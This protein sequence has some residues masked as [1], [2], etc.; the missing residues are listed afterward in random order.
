[1]AQRLRGSRGRLQGA[2]CAPALAL[3][4]LDQRYVVPFAPMSRFALLLVALFLG[5]SC[6]APRPP[7]LGKEYA[8]V[9][10]GTIYPAA[11]A[12]PVE[13]LLMVDG[14]VL[15][16][17]TLAEMETR[18]SD[19]RKRAMGLKRKIDLRRIDL[20]GGTAVP[21][22]VDAHGHLESLGE[23]L[24][25][26][27]LLGCTSV[28]ELVQRVAERAAQRP[29]GT[30]ICGRGWDQTLFPGQAFPVHDTLSA[31]V[32]EHP[33]YLER[34][35]GHAAFVNAMALERV[36]FTGTLPAIEGG[37]IVTDAGGR[38]TGVLVDEASTR[39]FE[40]IPK[41]DAATRARRILAAQKRLLS[42]GLVGMHDMGTAPET[43]DVLRELEKD[44]RLKLRVTSY[45]WGNKGLAKFAS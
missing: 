23:S 20:R 45:L 17:G 5:S 15:G 9:S 16:I 30:W 38:P 36:G 14:R 24:E 41:P 34:V 3:G 35:D 22:M 10:G 44:G 31:A 37:R 13:A 12:A 42:L 25:N 6:L 43:L 39:V 2:L 26:V 11:D 4:G 18:V 28:E 19:L 21:G 32:P 27:D 29:A 33:V 1:M 7:W 40:C 8:L